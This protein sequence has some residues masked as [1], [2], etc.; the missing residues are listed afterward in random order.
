M[1]LNN[2]N[3]ISNLKLSNKL[4]N[5]ES[6]SNLA[7]N[8]NDASFW[9]KEL[10]H[11]NKELKIKNILKQDKFN[12]QILIQ[13]ALKIGQSFTEKNNTDNNKKNKKKI[14][15]IK[16]IKAKAKTNYITNESEKNKKNLNEEF[17][18]ILDKCNDKTRIK[19]D[20]YFDDLINVKNEQTKIIFE[21]E[22]LESQIENINN[23][24]KFL[25]QRLNEKNEE[26]NKI[27]KSFD[28][29]NKIKPF[30][31]LIRQYPDKDPRQITHS[32]IKK[33]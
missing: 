2:Y 25:K 17:Q 33:K 27:I 22:N 14:E 3:S 16:E 7:N 1:E 13:K 24:S 32:N 6:N 12:S 20:K 10:Q 23:E 19:L 11:L 29:F 4:T 8:K 28:S 31:Q 9:I 26:I 30:F 18:E 15:L 21:N 5:L